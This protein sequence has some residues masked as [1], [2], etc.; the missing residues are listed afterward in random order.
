MS[1]FVGEG[2]H[3]RGGVSTDPTESWLEGCGM[4]QWHGQEAF[5]GHSPAPNLTLALHHCLQ[6]PSAG[7]TLAVTKSDSWSSSQQSAGPHSQNQNEQVF[8]TRI[9][10]KPTTRFSGRGSHQ[11][12]L[13]KPMQASWQC[14]ELRMMRTVTNG[15][16]RIRSGFR[17][18]LKTG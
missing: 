4:W 11:P 12:M 5:D 2:Y 7:T 6:L 1:R 3:A 17:E 9:Y 10:N 13:A 14:G 8:V 18:I 15:S 16:L